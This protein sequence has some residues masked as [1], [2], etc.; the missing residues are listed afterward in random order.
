MCVSVHVKAFTIRS[1]ALF[2]DKQNYV[3]GAILTDTCTEIIYRKVNAAS[4]RATYFLLKNENL[5]ISK[6]INFIVYFLPN[7]LQH[8]N[9]S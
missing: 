5:K 1:I 4:T 7:Q 2:P 3:G 6:A 8:Y 9:R